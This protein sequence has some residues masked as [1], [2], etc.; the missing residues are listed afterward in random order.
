MDVVMNWQEYSFIGLCTCWTAIIIYKV[1]FKKS[2]PIKI[3][4]ED[5]VAG[6]G[7]VYGDEKSRYNDDDNFSF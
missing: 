5:I 4:E 3:R 6:D 2:K 1:Y 7:S